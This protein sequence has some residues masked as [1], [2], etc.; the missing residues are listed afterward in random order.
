MAGAMPADAA[1]YLNERAAGGVT[2]E[3][4]AHACLRRYDRFEPEIRAWVA[5]DR[6]GWLAEAAA[7]DRMPALKTAAMPLAGVPVGVKDLIDTAAFPT[8]YGSS[9]YRGHRPLQDAAIVDRLRALGALVPGKTVTTEFACFAPGPTRNPHDV[10]LTP[11]GSSSG[12]AAAVAAGMVPMA[13][14]TQTAGSIIRPAAFCGIFGF[15]PSFGRLP[16]T[17]VKPLA[18]HLDTLGFFARSVDD[19][20]LL[21]EAFWPDEPDHVDHPPRLR[22]Y[23]PTAFGTVDPAVEADLERAGAAFAAAGLSVAPFTRVAAAQ[24]LTRAQTELMAVE[25]AAALARE[26]KDHWHALSSSLRALIDA[27]RAAVSHTA[28]GLLATIERAR[29]VILADTDWDI[30]VSLS[31]T[32]PPPAAAASTG[33]PGPCR[34]WTAAGFP[35]L[36]IPMARPGDLPGALQLIGR[37][38]TDRSLVAQVPRLADAASELGLGK[39]Q[40]LP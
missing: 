26:A 30:I 1:T 25:A 39:P 29:S 37:P 13:L 36:S 33:D 8:C 20:A 16:M 7:I 4:Y 6:P 24:A 12:S 28:D 38:G 9:V 35:A 14:G 23:S 22:L 10:R 2:A 32:G 15:K 5:L 19:L 31:A 27:G 3:A 11:G 17:G 21:A 34:A 18:P 40:P